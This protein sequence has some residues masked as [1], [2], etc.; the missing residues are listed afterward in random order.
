MATWERAGEARHHFADMIE[1]LTAAQ[2]K[3]IS[4]CDAWDAE[5][6]LA[7]ITAFVETGPVAFFTATAKSGFNFD[8]ASLAMANTQL[9]RPMADVLGSLRAKATK[10][11]F[12]PGF[13]E[14]M[15]IADTLIH[16]QDVRRP[17]G[18]HDMP[19]E[20]LLRSSLDFIT[21]HRM[22][23]TMV[24]RPPIDGV[25]LLATDLSWS[26]GDGPEIS[27]PAEALMMGLADRPVLDELSGEGLER[28]H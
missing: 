24:N 21:T 19:D 1:E 2:V 20:A 15:T 26:Y 10:A 13:P 22:A 23:T 6:V 17:N 25:R 12:A 7:H 9:E 16:T 14:E 3:T 8:K 4:L 18:I 28:W 5:G 11:G 27:G